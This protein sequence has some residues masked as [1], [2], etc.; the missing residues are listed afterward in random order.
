[1]SP[2]LKSSK[3]FLHP[4][5]FSE[6]VGNLWQSSEV[7]GNLQWSSEVCGNLRKP[8]ANLRKFRFCGDEKSQVFYWKKVGRYQIVHSSVWKTSLSTLSG[9][10][11]LLAHLSVSACVSLRNIGDSCRTWGVFNGLSGEAAADVGKVD[12]S[13][14]KHRH[15]LYRQCL[16]VETWFNPRFTE[17]W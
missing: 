3:I 8:S 10:F 1:M 9:I 6:V 12:L 13:C 4:R 14:P 5:L 17:T 11:L 2:V 7:T 15:Q 16:I